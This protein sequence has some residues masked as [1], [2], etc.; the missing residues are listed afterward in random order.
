MHPFSQRVQSIN[1]LT[2]IVNDQGNKIIGFS[3]NDVSFR[4]TACVFQ[5]GTLNATCQLN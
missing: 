2:R 5:L 4:I 3:R 1:D